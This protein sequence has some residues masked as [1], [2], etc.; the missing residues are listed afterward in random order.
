MS[1][2]MPR[3]KTPSPDDLRFAAEW[4]RQ[5]D[6][7]HDGGKQTAIAESVAEWLD[8]QAEAGNLRAAA[9]E[10]G[11][12]VAMLRAKVEEVEAINRGRA[13]NTE[14]TNR[15]GPTRSND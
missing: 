11:V 14:A 15:N 7:S 10:I 1:R 12:P 2:A 9:A 5:Y 4:L 13:A 8:A 3:M 6:D